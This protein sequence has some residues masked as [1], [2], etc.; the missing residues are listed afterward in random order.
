MPP[1]QSLLG[2]Y[3]RMRNGLNFALSATGSFL[4][5]IG[6]A[7]LIPSTG[8][9]DNGNLTYLIASLIIMCAQSWKI[10]TQG[11]TIRK[12]PTC[13]GTYDAANY[14]ND[15]S[16]LGVD[17][18]ALLGGL[19]YFV[20]STL[21]LPSVLDGP[22]EDALLIAAGAWFILGGIAYFLSGCFMSYRYLFT[23]NFPH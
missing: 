20:G 16:G 19:G 17:F 13:L 12:P 4:Y 22:G 11:T 21:F 1:P 23:K 2:K 6:S 7:L 15:L 14:L 10:I 18:C 9:T 5:V 8:Q 3:K